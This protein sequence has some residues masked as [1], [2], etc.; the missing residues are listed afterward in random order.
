MRPVDVVIPLGRGSRWDDNELRFCLRALDRNFL[1]LGNVWIVGEKPDWCVGVRYVRVPDFFSSNK[2][3]NLITK[4]M[5]A[6][7]QREMSPDFIRSS[8]DELLLRPMHFDAMRPYHHGEISRPHGNRWHRRLERT[9]RWLRRQG[10]TAY[11]YD[12]HLPVPMQRD[13]FLE[14]FGRASYKKRPG[15]T[16]D[17]TYFNC[18]GLDQHI[19]LPRRFRVRLD[20]RVEDTVRLHRILGRACYLNLTDRAVGPALEQALCAMFPKP[21]RFEKG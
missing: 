20:R 3:A 11:N 2:D 4:V 1:D 7:Y 19:P 9:G 14:I 6:C 21:S 15:L 12:S 10:L 13:R 16:I 18:C 8:D 5:T 17:S